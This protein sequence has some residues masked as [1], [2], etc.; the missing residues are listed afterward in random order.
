MVMLSFWQFDRL[1]ERKDFNR[2]VRSR[3]DAPVVDLTDLD[4]ADP[5][6]VEWRAVRVVGVNTDFLQPAVGNLW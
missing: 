5:A 3:S 1:A 2:D 6:G 4:L